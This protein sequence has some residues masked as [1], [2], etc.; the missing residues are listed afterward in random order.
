MTT[1]LPR[2]TGELLPE[3]LALVD[4]VREHRMQVGLSTE[5]CDRPATVMTVAAIVA[6]MRIVASKMRLES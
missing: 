6:A 3:H 2:F 1:T 5:R 4:E